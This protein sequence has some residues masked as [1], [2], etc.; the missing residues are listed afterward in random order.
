[1]ITKELIKSEIEDYA[2]PT[3]FKLG[4]ELLDK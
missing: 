3:A 2:I 4:K 1:M